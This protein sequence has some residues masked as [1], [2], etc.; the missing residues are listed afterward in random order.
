[1]SLPR[2][3]LKVLEPAQASLSPLLNVV[4][5]AILLTLRRTA[6]I[7]PEWAKQ[8]ELPSQLIPG[9]APRGV[10]LFSGPA[11]TP[12]SGASAK[13]AARTRKRLSE[14]MLLS[15]C[16]WADDNLSWINDIQACFVSSFVW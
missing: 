16:G 1:M 10:R 8:L 5:R 13:A 6:Y 7:S 3:S 12:L 15:W 14:G 11:T 9:L 4:P 2:P